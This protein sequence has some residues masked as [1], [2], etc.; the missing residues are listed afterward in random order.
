MA[1]STRVCQ[2]FSWW[3]LDWS[4]CHVLPA[5]ILIAMDGRYHEL[6]LHRRWPVSP[7]A[8]GSG[9]CVLVCPLPAMSFSS[10]PPL[11]DTATPPE[12]ARAYLISGGGQ[13]D[14]A[15]SLANSALGTA[16]G[17]AE[18]PTCSLR[19]PTTRGVPTGEW[20]GRCLLAGS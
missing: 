9:L 3:N 20:R 12:V 15:T 6:S 7:G 17:A 14:L 13:A 8:A 11:A 1:V 2:F 18:P 10:A 19:L 4:H 5:A 16:R